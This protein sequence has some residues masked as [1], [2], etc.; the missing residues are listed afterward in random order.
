MWARDFPKAHSRALGRTGG[1]R[2]LFGVCRFAMARRRGRTVR[3]NRAR[4]SNVDNLVGTS[5]GRQKDS[6][7]NHSDYWI[8]Q[9]GA[10]NVI[11]DL[12]GGAES[13]LNPAEVG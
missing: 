9:V 6:G 12:E 2:Q 4:S 8:E 10:F 13:V 11:A 7:N 1:P 3:M 5:P